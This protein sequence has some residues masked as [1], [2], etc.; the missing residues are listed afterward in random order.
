[1]GTQAVQRRL[2]AILSADVAGYSRLMGEDEAGTLAALKAHR[3]EFIDL[4]IAARGGRIVKLMGDGA[5]VEFASVVDAVECAVAVQRGMAERN[6]DV[7]EDTRIAFRVGVNLG[8]II[9]EGDDIYGDG[10][11]VA[12]RIQEIAAPGGVALSSVAHDQVEGKIEA[13][14]EDAGEHDLK[15]VAKPVRVFRWADGAAAPVREAPLALPDKPSIAVLPFTNM[16]GDP[17]QEYFSDGI[18]EDIITALSKFR[19]LFVIAR[20]SSFAFK[21][22]SVDVKELSKRLGV[23]YLVEGSVRRAG[24][25]V[26]ITAQL[27]DAVADAHLWAERYDRD[28]D[29]I[30]AV[31][32]EV[33][34]AIVTAIEPA[35]GSVERGRAHRKPTERLDAW[36][37]YQRGLWHS[38]RYTAADNTEAQSF[39]RRAIE[40]DPNFAPA[41]AGLGYAI[42]I[43]VLLG[44]RTDRAP[45][46]G[47]AR[48][49]AERAVMLDGDD[50]LGHVVVGRV[51][52][53]AG[54][55]DAAISACKTALALNPNLATARYGL[56]TALS[57]SG[58]Y[59]E[60]IVELDEA[61]RLSPRDPMLW[62]FLSI[63][64]EAYMAMERYEE[65]L[66]FVR[67]AQRQPNAAYSANMLEVVA[68]AQLDRIE[69]ARQALERVHAIKPDFDLNF[70]VN[71][72]KQ[73]R[74][75]GFEF[76]LD[77][78]KKA[79]L[80]N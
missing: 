54:E 48:D 5:L 29:D 22:Q 30:F 10:V 59:E 31:Q 49:A 76:L 27:V 19:S 16:S 57:W 45:A 35:L 74:A 69:E 64:A 43:S 77:G 17:E 44:F 28:L 65:G 20:N 9:V 75:V 51:H 80:E 67:A 38:Y 52:L 73:M 26:R 18:S 63:K 66:E 53:M 33:T 23:R 24:N 4:E 2:A 68:L 40:L 58:R 61:I 14:F 6:A 42:Y 15:N 60:G 50:A 12:A 71:T 78:L 62:A 13:A 39:F 41:H 21:G 47:E 55:Y 25:R 46:L 7:P 56:G 11:N 32:D 72:V 36:E 3:A 8:D 34:H 70:I 79:G 1:M 37:S